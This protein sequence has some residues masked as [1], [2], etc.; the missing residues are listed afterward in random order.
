MWIQTGSELERMKAAVAMMPF[1]IRRPFCEFR[2]TNLLTQ[3]LAQ[4]IASAAKQPRRVSVLR[5]GVTGLD[6]KL[7]LSCVSALSGEEV[8]TFGVDRFAT[9]A[10]T[11]VKICEVSG[12]HFVYLTNGDVRL[13]ETGFATLVASVSSVD[14]CSEA[15]ATTTASTCP[16]IH[17]NVRTS[18]LTQ[19]NE[20]GTSVSEFF[21]SEGETREYKKIAKKLREIS[22][23]EQLDSQKLDKLQLEKNQP[24]GNSSECFGVPEG[25]DWLPIE[26]LRFGGLGFD[27]WL[28]LQPC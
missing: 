21:L 3:E 13:D 7:T 12:F 1:I 15:S 9:L 11:I 24:E 8:C 27:W 20:V 28:L 16:S 26:V 10:E 2:S 4:M 6:G 14:T 5:L 18:H 23:L 25:E 17:P 19:S 22:K